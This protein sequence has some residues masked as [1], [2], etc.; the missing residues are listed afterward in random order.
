MNTKSKYFSSLLIAIVAAFGYYILTDFNI[1]DIQLKTFSSLGIPFKMYQT[2]NSVKQK[3][4]PLPKV[5]YAYANQ[6]DELKAPRVEMIAE[7]D[8]DAQEFLAGLTGALLDA[9]KSKLRDKGSKQKISDVTNY[10]SKNDN[11]ECTPVPEV[12]PQIVANPN[13]INSAPDFKVQTKISKEDI[14][15]VV[16]SVSQ[17]NIKKIEECFKKI[18]V[19]Y[20]NENAGTKNIIVTNIQNPNKQTR[21]T[22]ST[23]C[24]TTKCTQENK[25][26]RKSTAVTQK[27]DEEETEDSDN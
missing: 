6:Q 2:N 4:L 7:S 16:S 12:P 9:E 20:G 3:K 1:K 13:K 11:I 10:G 14:E 19:I 8:S 17:Q 15:M 25:R 23:T 22:C 24:P 18:K 21:S 27:K 26:M 5:V